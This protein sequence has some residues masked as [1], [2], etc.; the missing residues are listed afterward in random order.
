MKT[1]QIILLLLIS[2]S[3]NAQSAKP[4]CRMND[5]TSC[6]SKNYWSVEVDPA[7]FILGGYSFS[8]KY[9]SDRFKHL[10]FMGSVYRSE[11]PDNMMSNKN[12]ENGFRNLKINTSTAFFADY[13]I[14]SNRT[15]FHFGPSVFYY[16]KSVGSNSTDEVANFKSVYPN[17]RAGYVFKPFKNNGFYIN[18]WFNVGK[19]FVIG[20][21]NS[22]DNTEFVPDKISYIVAIHLGYQLF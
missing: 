19:E 15:G 14:K 9:S 10:T 20:N 7:P 12:Y 3:A 6:Y 4:T 18:P 8:L 16:C 2:A 17:I 22:I 11:F 13:F 1:L 5:T 21:N